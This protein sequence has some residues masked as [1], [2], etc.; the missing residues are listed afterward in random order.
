MVKKTCTLVGLL[1]THKSRLVLCNVLRSCS[2]DEDPLANGSSQRD[3]NAVA[4]VL[5][6]YF[7]ELVEPLF[8]G[9]LFDAL[10][11]ASSKFDK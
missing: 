10:I 8:P 3:I 2:I 11:E 1:H 9:T 7:R 6:L 5:K 4:G